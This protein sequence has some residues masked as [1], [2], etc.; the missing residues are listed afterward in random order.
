MT[1]VGL[2]ENYFGNR[3]FLIRKEKEADVNRSVAVSETCIGIW[4]QAL[5]TNNK[6]KVRIWV[7]YTTRIDDS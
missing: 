1:V 7:N 5:D 2:I 3:H 4:G 6:K